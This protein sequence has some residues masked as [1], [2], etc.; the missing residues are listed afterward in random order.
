MVGVSELMFLLVL[1]HP[2][3]PRQN[4]ESRKTFVVFRYNC[5]TAVKMVTLSLCKGNKSSNNC[6]FYQRIMF[7][8][9]GE[10]EQ[11]LKICY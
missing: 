6:E 10:G 4:L 11:N 9:Q 1:A 8:L 5:V 2:G 3:C 7:I